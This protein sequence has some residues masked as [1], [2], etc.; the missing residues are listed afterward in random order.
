MKLFSFRNIRILLL[1]AILAFVAIYTKQQRIYSTSWLEPLEVVI[2]PINGDNNQETDR[3]I[4]GLSSTSFAAIDRFT[5][6]ESRRHGLYQERPTTTRLGPPLAVPPPSPPPRDASRLKIALWSLQL[7][8]WA[9]RHTPDDESNDNRV[10]IFVLYHGM[11]NDKPL[12]HSLGLQ[13]GLLGV[14]HG[15]ASRQ[16]NKQNNLVI[17]HELLHTVGASDKYDTQGNPVF[18]DGY[19]QPE[20]TPLFPQ[21]RAEIMAGRIPDSRNESRMAMSLDSCMIGTATAREISWLEQEQ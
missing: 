8:Y 19:A 10:R 14:V 15:Y 2:F 18:P 12:Q 20:R 1:L 4:S 21:F 16:Q 6:R 7:R 9:W 11:D 13:K 17:A 3:Y 5:A